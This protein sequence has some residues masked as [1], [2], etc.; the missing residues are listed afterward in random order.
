MK[1]PLRSMIPF[2]KTK[3]GPM[4]HKGFGLCLVFLLYLS[5]LSCPG[6][7]DIVID[8]VTD[9]SVYV[10]QVSLQVH[11]E[12]GFDT[13]ATLNDQ[14][15]PLDA[16]LDIDTPEYYELYVRQKE[17]SSGQEQEE[18]IRFI[19]RASERGITEVGLPVWTPYPDI[20][21]AES[22]F[23]G[24]ELNIIMPGTWPVGWKI[25]VVARVENTSQRRVGVNG[26][27]RFDDFSEDA[28]RLLRGVG[29]TWLSAPADTNRVDVN[30]GIQ[31]LATQKTI[32]LEIDTAW[33]VVSQDIESSLD[34]GTNALIHIQPALGNQL[35]VKPDADIHIG[36]GS[37]VLLDPD[38]T[39][40]VQGSLLVNGTKDQPVVFVPVDRDN[41]W[42]GFLFETGN[43]QGTFTHTILTGSGADDH[44]FDN[45]SNHGH[46]HLDNQCLFYI[47]NNAHVSLADCAMI[48]NQGQIGH[49]EN[50]FLTMTRCL[51]QRCQTVGQFNGGAVIAWN[52]AFIEFPSASAG[53]ADAD[54]DA[55]YLTSG[56]HALTDCL[57]GWALDDALDAGDGDIGSVI[58]KNCWFESCY[59]EAMAWSS[60]PRYATV[61]DSVALNCGQAIECGYGK[62]D[63]HSVRCLA[64]DNLVGARF[65]DNYDWDY[66][67][68]LKVSDSLLLFNHRDVWAQAWDD[69]SVH[70]NQ[71][72]IQ[73][74]YVTTLNPNFPDNTL[75]AP[76]NNSDQL[77]LLEAFQSTSGT[78]VGVGLAISQDV[79]DKTELEN[80]LPVRLSRFTTETVSVD[81]VVKNQS[82]T[83]DSGTLTFLPGQT[84]QSILIPSSASDSQSLVE[85]TLS[86]PLNAEL[87]S[88][89]RIIFFSPE[90]L[91]EPL[92]QLGDLWHYFKGTTAPSALWNTLLFDDAAWTVGPTP[93]GYESSSG[94]EN[95]LATT[96]NDMRN[97]Y[98]CVF[99]RRQFYIEDPVELQ[100]LSLTLD[101][102]D[103]YIVYL[104]G[105]RVA[106]RNAPAPATYDQP[107]NGSHEACCGTCEVNPIDLSEFLNVLV[108]GI[109]VLSIQAHNRSFD[110]SDFIFSPLLTGQR[111]PSF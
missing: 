10:N 95:C 50:G 43:A 29:S 33:Q 71:T 79:L 69:W 17:I 58:V 4:S 100:S 62:P 7:A 34:F 28:L 84:L 63:V 41:P 25:P 98:L 54:N 82:D 59:H 6:F 22:E 30:A 11:S 3:P 27:V 60:G 37:I 96:L 108:P 81:Y 107:A 66:D 23:A 101:Y 103:G 31:S 8:G 48:D 106:E 74:N 56:A 19:V 73:H 18:L 45:H 77:N 89:Q 88:R 53:Y 90:D 65:G 99:A 47:S 64:V 91:I 76:K 51:V 94:Y 109:N 105:V 49:G 16:T 13:M 57:L 15:I 78:T 26:T 21:S 40:D 110:S 93:I 97:N 24:T 52:S 80:P 87:T 42:G 86:N 92:I 9:K 12:A 70:L 111:R 14:A 102:D 36:A 20:D 38:V 44:W 35:T 75:W 104:N 67:G 1:R 85:I 61:L 39:L 46:S 2:P 5:L 83:L 32:V 55:F 68:F 72:D